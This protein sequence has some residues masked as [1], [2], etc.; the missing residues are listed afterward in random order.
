[1][2]TLYYESEEA[3]EN[4]RKRRRAIMARRQVR[5]LAIIQQTKDCPCV[6]CGR[7]F[8]PA[9]M[10]FD[11][12]R[13]V[14]TFEINSYGANR[15]SETSLRLELAKCDVRCVVCHRARHAGLDFKEVWDLTNSTKV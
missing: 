1:M 10:E 5:N 3:K 2:S 8:P 15:R 4:Y 13:G 9:C 14:K 12:V 7:Q 6:D 11:H